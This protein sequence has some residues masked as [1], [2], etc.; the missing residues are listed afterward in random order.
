MSG[1]LI[2]FLHYFS[3]QCLILLNQLSQ[4]L[5]DFNMTV[6]VESDWLGWNETFC[7][8]SFCQIFVKTQRGYSDFPFDVVNQVLVLSPPWNITE[9]WLLGLIRRHVY[10]IGSGLTFFR[11]AYILLFSQRAFANRLW[12]QILPVSSV[13][14]PL[15]RKQVLEPVDIFF[16]NWLF[17]VEYL[18]SPLQM[19]V[20]KSWTDKLRISWRY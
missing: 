19:I 6:W 14:L 10:S 7:E 4:I 9:K 2:V 13:E 8:M 12:A 5:I 15:F 3:F 18:I 16:Y 1:N 17:M 20:R 11:C